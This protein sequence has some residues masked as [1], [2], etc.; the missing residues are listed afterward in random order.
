MVNVI[1][2]IFLDIFDKQRLRQWA[3]GDKDWNSKF[4][5]LFFFHLTQVMKKTHEET[6]SGVSHRF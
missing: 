6:S 3:N 2:N 4:E 1:L 5:F